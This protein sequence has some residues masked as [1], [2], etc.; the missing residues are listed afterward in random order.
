MAPHFSQ[1][2]LIFAIDKSSSGSSSVHSSTRY[3]LG[4]ELSYVGETPRAK[5]GLLTVGGPPL[6]RKQQLVII[7]VSSIVMVTCFGIPQLD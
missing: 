1:N 2:I 7:H 3:I 5:L 4:T 6:A